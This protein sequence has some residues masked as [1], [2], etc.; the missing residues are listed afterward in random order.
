MAEE[1][2][3]ITHESITMEE[4]EPKKKKT[5]YQSLDGG[6]GVAP[7]V[8]AAYKLYFQ[9]K[10]SVKAQLAITKPTNF[11]LFAMAQALEHMEPYY[12]ESFKTACAEASIRLPMRAELS[13]FQEYLRP[14]FTAPRDEK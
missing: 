7:D 6:S 13:A 3:P 2:N 14:T 9:H 8:L 11:E 4:A 1:E 12:V 10:S 5:K